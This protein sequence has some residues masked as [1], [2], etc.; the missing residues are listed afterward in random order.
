[1]ANPIKKGDP[2]TMRAWAFYDWANSVYPLVI[3]TAIFPIFYETVTSTKVDGKTV[4]DIVTFFGHEIKNTVLYS[5]VVAASLLMV[6]VLSPFLSGI[7]DYAGSKKRFM[8]FFCYLGAVSVA[9]LYFFNDVPLEIAMTFLFLASL[10]FW[11]SLVFYNAYLPEVAEPK[12]H[13]KLSAQGFSMGYF[14]SALLLISLLVLMQ[15]FE[16][17]RAKDC[18]WIT[19]LWWI[20][21]SQITYVRLPNNTS[22]NKMTG[23]ILG[24]GF[25]E[26]KKVG[27]FIKTTKRLKRYLISFFIFSMGVQTVMLMA[28]LFA[29][30]EV[31]KDGNTAGLIIAVL[32]IQFIAIPGSL[33][34]SLL[35]KKLGN[36][37]TLGIALFVWVI[38]CAFAYYFVYDEINFYILA[39]IVGFVMGGTQALSRSTYSKFL[40]KT[41]DTASFF[42]FYDIT[43]KIGIVIGMVI[44]GLAEAYS[45]N[46]R[47]S[48]L[49][50]MVF[51]V[52]G[53]VALW[54][55]PKEENASMPGFVEE[56]PH[57]DG[58]EDLLDDSSLTA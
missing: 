35:S 3:S 1:M 50:L 7:A 31:F 51:F 23:K 54:F 47:F 46:M 29:K 4:S 37:K 36:L 26:L 8:Q 24:D 12:D 58:E 14:G 48:V 21:F 49:A 9:A 18:F 5:Y 57:F 10:G 11:N 55:V 40:P 53:F 16:V 30:K 33:L 56:K 52:V 41:K 39:G 34:F 27:Q 43:E 25:R 22:K 20:G 32:L 13:D 2:K 17:I 28:V 42:S 38:C 6:S 15:Y 45:G 44:F 19:G